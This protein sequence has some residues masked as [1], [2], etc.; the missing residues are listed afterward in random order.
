VA[1]SPARQCWC[2]FTETLTPAGPGAA[3]IIMGMDKSPP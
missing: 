1:L 2:A 3:I